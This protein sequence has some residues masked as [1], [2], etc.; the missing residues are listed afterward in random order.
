M[1]F[2]NPLQSLSLH[3]FQKTF[4]RMEFL[5]NEVGGN[6]LLSHVTMWEGS[7][8]KKFGK[9]TDELMGKYPLKYENI[10]ELQSY[11]DEDKITLTD[12]E[13]DFFEREYGE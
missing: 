8:Q 7:F 1:L 9:E 4:A 2:I 5:R 12:D 3:L 13:R 10:C 6:T 11:L